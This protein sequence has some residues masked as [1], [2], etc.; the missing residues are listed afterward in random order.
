MNA[1]DFDPGEYVLEKK[2][3]NA[4][5][6]V[7]I[8]NPVERRPGHKPTIPGVYDDLY[9]YN[10]GTQNSAVNP[11]KTVLTGKY[12]CSKQKKLVVGSIIGIGAIALIA[13]GVILYL[14]GRHY[15]STMVNFS[16]INY[17]VALTFK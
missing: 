15:L 2:K 12:G 1:D 17:D 13:F 16:K 11:E 3:T 14:Q 8:P 6:E 7:A 4:S 10:T 9:D 5:V